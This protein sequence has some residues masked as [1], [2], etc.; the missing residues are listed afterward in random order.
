MP[1]VPAEPVVAR[2]AAGSR[3]RLEVD[4]LD[5]YYAHWPNPFVSVRRTMQAL[6]PLVADGAVRRVGVSNYGLDQ[7]QDAERALRAPVIANQVKFS[8]VSAGPAL[9]LVPYAAAMDRIVVAYS[10]LAQGLL[11]DGLAESAPRPRG[12]RRASSLFQPGA[13]RRL[14][15]LSALLHEIADAHGATPAQVALAWVIRHPNTIAIPGARTIEQLEENAA[16]AD[17]ALADD[18]FARLSAEASMFADRRRI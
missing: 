18:E 3:R 14:A 5:L 7:W 17:L 8:L 6:R 9:D 4:A 16:A 1:I 2:Q 13:R 10:P 12:V 15:P 11:T